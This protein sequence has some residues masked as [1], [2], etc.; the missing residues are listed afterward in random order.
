MQEP[1]EETLAQIFESIL[2]GYFRLRN[3][4]EKL[5][6]SVAVQASIDMYQQVKDTML[7]IP[8]KFHYTFNL[9]DMANVFQGILMCEPH[10]IADADGYAKLWLHECSR[11][12]ADR[13]C[14]REDV[15]AYQDIA[16]D[17]LATK[18]KVKWSKPEEAFGPGKEIIF[19]KILT[20]EY[21]TQYY[22]LIEDR[23]KLLQCL[24]EKLASYNLSAP[25]KMDLVFFSDAV[26]HVMSI[27]RTLM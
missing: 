6:P 4:N 14:T 19:S 21:E 24:H 12:F 1:A 20:L 16:C 8:A 7:P 11:V 26:T 15:E 23:G 10:K 27:M 13:L 17:I 18:F 25:S 9:R 3:A 5:R 2:G 22:E